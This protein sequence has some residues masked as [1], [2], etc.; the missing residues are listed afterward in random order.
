MASPKYLAITIELP[1]VYN[2][3]LFDYHKSP[4][5]YYF[6][7]AAVNDLPRSLTNK[8]FAYEKL[9]NRGKL[10]YDQNNKLKSLLKLKDMEINQL[11]TK[12]LQLG[13]KLEIMEHKLEM[14][15]QNHQELDVDEQDILKFQ[16]TFHDEL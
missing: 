14:I 5:S 8:V 12:I 9:L 6:P 16:D 15:D 1:M 10:I 2:Y 4:Y 7:V 13:Q 11:Q 3:S